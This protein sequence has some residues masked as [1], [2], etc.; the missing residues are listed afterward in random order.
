MTNVLSTMLN[1]KFKPS[2]EIAS[3]L[4]YC[5]VK[6]RSCQVHT[7]TRSP[8]ATASALFRP[9]PCGT[10]LVVLDSEPASDPG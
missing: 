4:A 6:H 8:T 5:R 1:R 2:S 7:G 9:M 3:D 10:L